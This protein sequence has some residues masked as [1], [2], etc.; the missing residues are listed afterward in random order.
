MY[1]TIAIKKILVSFHGRLDAFER[2]V[3]DHLS[4]AHTPNM[5]A[6]RA[7]IQQLC[8][9]IK[10]ASLAP[11]V[12]H[13]PTVGIEVVDLFTAELLLRISGKRHCDDD[14]EAIRLDAARIE[15][16]QF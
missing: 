15:S 16:E 13:M 2:R 1:S 4:I 6:I 14:V 5:I 11:L 7:D 9:D 8:T 3:E 10:A 12:I